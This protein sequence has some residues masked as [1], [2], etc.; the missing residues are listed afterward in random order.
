MSLKE[1]AVILSS[2]ILGAF[3]NH[4]VNKEINKRTREKDKFEKFMIFFRDHQFY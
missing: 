2:I 1:K 3:L 4:Y